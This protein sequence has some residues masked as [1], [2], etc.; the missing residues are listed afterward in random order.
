MGT[1]QYLIL[2]HKNKSIFFFILFSLFAYQNILAQQ[3]ENHKWIKKTSPIYSD[4]NNL[5]LFP[6]QTSIA[7]GK[8]VLVLKNGIWQKM[9]SQPSSDINLLCAKSLE[10]IFVT[11]KTEFQESELFYWNG[12]TWEEFYHPLANTIDAMRFTDTRNGVIG[13]LGE[14]AI[15]ENNKWKFLSPPTNKIITTIQ[16]GNNKTIWALAL[17]EGLYKY[18]NSWRKI[19]NSKNIKMMKLFDNNLY[20]IGSDYFG[21]V[22]SD[23]IKIISKNENL[24]NVRSFE[25]TNKNKILAVGVNGII[26]SYT[27]GK[28]IEKESGAD[29]HLNSV[30]MNE[31]MGWCVG[32]DG[33]ILKLTDKNEGNENSNNWKG[34]EEKTFYSNAKVVDDEY[35]VVT[36]DF[37]N[38]G[39]TDIFTCGLYE[40]NHLYINKGEFNFSDESNERGLNKQTKNERLT[41][42]LNLGA[43]AGDFD[44]DGEIDIYVTSLTSQNK[45]YHNLGEGN[46]V[47]YSMIAKGV[48]ES[49]DRTNAVIT[50]DVDNDGDLDIFITN[51]NTTNRFY[52]INGAGIFSEVTDKVN[53]ISKFGGTGASFADIDNDGDLDLF[54][55]NWSS[56]NVLYKNHFTEFGIL[57]FIDFTDS[58]NVGGENYSKS[59]GVVF[60][61][62]DN[63]AD[64]DMYVTNRKTSNKFYKNNGK[65]FFK[66]E[67]LEFFGKDSL[68]SYGAV[69]VDFD[70]DGYKDLYLSNVGS[71]KF[72]QNINGK[73]F[74]DKTDLF[75]AD[76]K[77]YSTGL[78]SADFNNDGNLD[79]Y[80]ANYIGSSSAILKNK[81]NSKKSVSINIVGNKNNTSAIGAKIYAYESGHLGKRSNLLYYSEI[82]GG[83][84]YASMN[85]PKQIVPI[86]NN[87]R[88]DIKIIFPLGEETTQMYVTPGSTISLSDTKRND[89]RYINLRKY[90]TRILFD[91][92]RLFE[93][94]KWIFLISLLL[95][96]AYIGFKKYS[97][98]L[99]VILTSTFS[100]LLF[101]SL[102]QTFFEYDNL[103]FSTILPMTSVFVTIAIIHLSYDRTKLKQETEIEKQKL[104]E[105]FSRDLHDD[106]AGTIGSVTIYLELLKQ[107]LRNNSNDIW[108]FFNKAESLLINAK[109]NITDL[110]WTIKPKPER[111][112]SFITKIRENFIP[113]FKER[114]IQLKVNEINLHEY[115][116]LSSIE[117]HNVYL[118]IKESLNNILKHANASKVEI[119][120]E[121]KGTT[122][123]F[124][125]I[126]NGQGFDKEH[127]V[128]R[129]NGLSNMHG[130]CDEL[131][132]SL[133]VES[134]L[135]IGSKVKLVLK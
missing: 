26:L 95:F 72:Y 68:K 33:T 109:Q 130:R 29:T 10:S 121:Q 78:A 59:N 48:G 27:N 7:S 120:I 104:R 73:S 103:F 14:I 91:P 47:D 55:A 108:K 77:G 131:N 134:D 126:D 62:I 42:G 127:F 123:E 25:V 133:S 93:F 100:L 38:D 21:V 40:K 39:L 63:D 58:A 32:N 85:D 17:S 119:A 135:G 11:T 13:G 6:N 86:P 69:I 74:L 22:I 18:N 71:N 56:K 99:K 2:I 129:G 116:F 45:I 52:I 111:V 3:L 65:G 82:N 128:K 64:M 46:F 87:K 81:A 15:L 5:F 28:W 43:C 44:N 107:A 36:A 41:R 125:I 35:G 4:L 105:K 12:K 51:E 80:I 106:L 61:D 50:G 112:T 49:G 24:K 37:N 53:L 66:D 34:F 20:I 23:S 90:I 84:G 98:S 94:L 19:Q 101:Y 92:H 75:E 57:K 132:A 113:I 1:L 124:N 54:V 83:S 76:I 115:K 89:E 8:Q 110:I 67:T 9:K 16:I 31:N 114:N 97:W 79:L 60:A 30:S 118:I 70:N 102:F 117:K 96:S 122:L 88:I